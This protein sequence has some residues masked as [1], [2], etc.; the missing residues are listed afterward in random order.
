MIKNAN[1]V[2]SEYFWRDENFK[3]RVKYAY[4]VGN[5]N[6][7]VHFDNIVPRCHDYREI[8]FKY[9]AC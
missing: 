6:D 2:Q 8:Y 3:C 1:T 7:V 9:S 5:E 4:A